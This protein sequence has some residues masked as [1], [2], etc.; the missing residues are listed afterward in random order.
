M[1]ITYNQ[2]I[3]DG[4]TEE[5]ARGRALSSIYGGDLIADGMHAAGDAAWEEL[6]AFGKG[7]SAGAHINGL[8]NALDE[9][10]SSTVPP[11][12][13]EHSKREEGLYKMYDSG[14]I[15]T[16]RDSLLIFQD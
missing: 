15:P 1:S 8:I 13:Q 3:A 11:Y 4:M 9:S 7:S 2:A 12:T 5:Q 10:A 16:A 6:G 14:K